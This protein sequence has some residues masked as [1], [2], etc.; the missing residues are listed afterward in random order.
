MTESLFSDS[1]EFCS[2][3][4]LLYC[5]WQLVR[6]M[7]GSS[8]TT[9]RGIYSLLRQAGLRVFYFGENGWIGH[10][11]KSRIDCF[12]WS[13]NLCSLPATNITTTVMKLW[14]SCGSGDRI[15]P[16]KPLDNKHDIINTSKEWYF[17]VNHLSKFN[18]LP[19][20]QFKAVAAIYS[21]NAWFTEG[22]I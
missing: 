22:H 17:R 21:P 4:S 6:K 10:V 20:L 13:R 7:E 3:Q 1:F 15:T 18:M 12:R 14:N 16:V 5:G 19:A 11:L 2:G 8:R 9:W